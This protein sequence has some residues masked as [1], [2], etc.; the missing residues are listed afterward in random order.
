VKLRPGKRVV[1]GTLGIAHLTIDM[2]GTLRVPLVIDGQGMQLFYDTDD[3]PHARKLH[4]RRFQWLQE[5]G[6]VELGR[7][8]RQ[9]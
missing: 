3:L 8:D 7:A 9:F 1:S 4:D 6:A 2:Q 5:L